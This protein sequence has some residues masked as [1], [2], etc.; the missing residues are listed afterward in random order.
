MTN[1]FINLL[2]DSFAK[3]SLGARF[4]KRLKIVSGVEIVKNRNDAFRNTNL[5]DVLTSN[6]ISDLYIVGLD[7]AQCIK[8]TVEAAQ[9]RNYKVDL[10]EEAILSKSKEMKD[11]MM[12]NFNA[13]GVYV[14]HR[15]SLDILDI[16]E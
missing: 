1:P 14:I 12:V 13:R 16:I 4:D 2:N 6:K 8:A 10:I 3:G 11:S 5:D 15:D 7:A 9:Y